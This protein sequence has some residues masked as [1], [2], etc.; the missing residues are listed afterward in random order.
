MIQ[1]MGVRVSSRGR[2]EPFYAMEL[3]KLANQKRQTGMD[4]ISLCLGQPAA[5]APAVVR[6]AAIDALASGSPLGYTDANGI[7]TLR[8][9]ISAHYASGYGVEVDP[10]RVLVTTGSSAAFTAI[11]LA[12]FESGDAVAMARPGYPAYRN[13]LGALGCQVVDLDCGPQTGFQPT[14]EMLDALPAP[15]AGLIVASPANPTGTIIEPGR[16]AAIADWCSGHGTLLISDEIYHGIS[17]GGPTASVL[18]GSDRHVAV[19]SFS[20]YYCMTGWRV[21]WLVVPTE[22]VR[23]VE[24][25]LGNLNLSTPTLSQLAAVTAFSPDARVE[26]DAHVARYRANRDLVLRRL[27]DI[28][29]RDTLVPDGAFYVYPDISHLTDDSLGWCLRALDEIGVALTPGVDFAPLRPG[30]VSATDGSR[31]M[32]I[33]TAG[34]AEQIDEAFDRLLSWV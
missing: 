32:R 29:V 15:P 17:F 16:L 13:V 9:A 14:V 1:P 31:Y 28:G 30:R 21:G 6:R 12:A 3:L 4:V 18:Q 26:L 10:A 34:A 24:L 27:P 2:V 19:G 7:P 22:L 5:G 25:L 8:A 33:S 11:L 23:N 20:K